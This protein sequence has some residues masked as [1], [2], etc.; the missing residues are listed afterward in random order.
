[1]IAC[2]FI[3]AAGGVDL[4]QTMAY[5]IF[6]FLLAIMLLSI[7]YSLL[8]PFRFRFS[9]T[10]MLPRFGTVGVK[11]EYRLAISNR[12]NRLQRGL[13]I[14]ENVADPRPSWQEFRSTSEPSEEKRN[15]F[16]RK[17]GYYR[18]MWLIYRKQCA[19]F[20]T[21]DLPPLPPNST[22]E[23]AME[24]EPLYRGVVRL[25]GLTIARSDPFGIFNACK[26]ISLPQ[27]LWILPHRYQLPPIRLPGSRR[28][29]SGGVSLASSVGDSEEFMSLRDYRPGDPLRKIHW[30]SWAKVGKPIVK[31]EQDE[32]FVRHALILDTF[33]KYQYSESLEAA[34]SVA[35]SFACE[36]QTQDAL[37]DLMFVG[38]EAYCFTS[39]RGVGHTDRMLEILAAVIPCRDKSFDYLTPVVISRTSMLSGCIC[40]LLSWDAERRKLVDYLRGLRIPTLVLVIVDSETKRDDLDLGAIANEP[41]DFHLLRL[42]KI[43]EELMKI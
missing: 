33:G 10:R 32:F 30:K 9:A 13:K 27:T 23:V 19:T 28:Y 31:E 39:G 6:C 1:M 20:K 16:D 7:A 17:F 11:I 36:F 5:Q 34:V 41:E 43:P 22:T 35:A 38:T 4:N 42:G 37:L 18:W 26:T 21:V 40:I 15:T 29:Q 24:I 2:L 14:F 8:V 12:T 25:S 3:A